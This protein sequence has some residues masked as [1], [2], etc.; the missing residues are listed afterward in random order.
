MWFHEGWHSWNDEIGK[1]AGDIE[2]SDEHYISTRSFVKFENHV[3]FMTL[4]TNEACL[5]RRHEEVD[6]ASENVSYIYIY[7]NSHVDSNSS[8]R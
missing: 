7:V 5:L 2:G 6:Y 1:K 8:K 4:E 3:V